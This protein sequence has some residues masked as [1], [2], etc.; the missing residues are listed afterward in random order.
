MLGSYSRVFTVSQIP[1]SPAGFRWIL[2]YYQ[3]FNVLWESL[4]LQGCH[5]SF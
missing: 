2:M 1:T 5:L 4:D 3:T